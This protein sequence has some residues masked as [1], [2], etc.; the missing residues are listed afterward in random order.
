MSDTRYCHLGGEWPADVHGC[1]LCEMCWNRYQD[2]CDDSGRDPGD[3]QVEAILALCTSIRERRRQS[4]APVDADGVPIRVGDRLA[5][6]SYPEIILVAIG[7]EGGVVLIRHESNGAESKVANTT[8][9]RHSPPPE[10]KPSERAREESGMVTGRNPGDMAKLVDG[11]EVAFKLHDASEIV[12]EI[13]AERVELL[14][15]IDQH[16][17]M[18]WLVCDHPEKRWCIG[19]LRAALGEPPL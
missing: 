19:D 3:I 7:V 16:L 1:Q 18:L 2:I 6:A 13:V 15:R 12:S 11:L 9:L 10:V 5:L 8:I 4:P 14:K 17:R